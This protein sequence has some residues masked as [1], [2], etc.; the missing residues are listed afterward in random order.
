MYFKQNVH[1]FQEK[2]EWIETPTDETVQEGKCDEVVFTAKLSHEGKKGKWYC[3][4]EV[5][6]FADV[7][8]FRT[9][10]FGILISVEVWVC[11]S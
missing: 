9:L 6:S 11:M 1:N 2:F 4:N 3:R 8:I 10:G 7:F 5:S